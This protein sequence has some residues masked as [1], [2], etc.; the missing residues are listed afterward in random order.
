MA[1]TDH[2]AQLRR[3]AQQHL[4]EIETEIADEE[5]QAAQARVENQRY[6]KISSAERK[7]HA[8]SQPQPHDSDPMPKAKLRQF[9]DILHRLRWDPQYRV[10]DYVVGYIERFEGIKEMSASNWIRDFSDEEWIPMHRARYVKR[11]S[12]ADREDGAQAGAGG[13]ATGSRK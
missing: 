4:T 6:I 11:I 3:L 12:G 1:N 7:K 8:Q 13:G 2:L 10:D 5:T 9:Q